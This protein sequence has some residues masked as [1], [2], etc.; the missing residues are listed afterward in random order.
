VAAGPARR[1]IRLRHEPDAPGDGAD[2]IYRYDRE[3]L[4]N[5]LKQARMG[6]TA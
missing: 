1:V 2:S 3:A 6:E 4:L 5:A